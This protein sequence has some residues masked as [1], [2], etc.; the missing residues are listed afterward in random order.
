MNKSHTLCCSKQNDVVEQDCLFSWNNVKIIN[1]C[2][3]CW[4]CCCCRCSIKQSNDL[5]F[6]KMSSEKIDENLA[7]VFQVTFLHLFNKMFLKLEQ[8]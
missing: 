5:L 8:T 3:W 7:I 6:Q 4:C 2:R 1:L